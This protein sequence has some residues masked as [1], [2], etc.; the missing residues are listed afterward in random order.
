MVHARLSQTI[1]VLSEVVYEGGA[2]E[3]FG[4]DVE[5]LMVTWEPVRWLR[6]SAGRYHTPLG[7][8]NVTHHHAKWMFV[9]ADAPLLMRYE[10]Q[11]G[12][13]PMHTIGV[14]AHGA[15]HLGEGRI[16]Y[17]L[18]AGNGRG[19]TS[20]PPQSFN[21]VNEGKSV[22]GAIHLFQGPLRIGVSGAVDQTHKLKADGPVLDEQIA[23]ADVVLSPGMLEA[24]A[25]GALIHHSSLGVDSTDLGGYV[26]V[27][28]GVDERIRPYVRVERYVHDPADD[29]LP[30]PTT[31]ELLGGLRFDPISSL[32]LKLEG[33]F[34]R[35]SGSDRPAL[36]AQAAWLF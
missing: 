36:R 29:Y 28:Y 18:G 10:D 7:Y 15:I 20:D 11:N 16:E 13:L 25:E 23:M 26:Q 32:A 12:P 4:L 2:A 17:D 14:L 31:T 27:S 5:R 3:G 22:V 9:T 33:A 19:P 1:S 35:V 21:D 8:W 6:I 30:T 34:L 24:V